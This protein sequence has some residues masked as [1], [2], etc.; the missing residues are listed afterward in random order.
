[1][2]QFILIS[3]VNLTRPPLGILSLTAVMAIYAFPSWVF[4]IFSI[5]FVHGALS[6]LTKR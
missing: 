1:M 3:D 4:K 6:S 5:M 2:K